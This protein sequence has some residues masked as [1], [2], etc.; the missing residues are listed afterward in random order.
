MLLVSDKRHLYAKHKHTV[1]PANTHIHTYVTLLIKSTCHKYGGFCSST[2]TLIVL[3]FLSHLMVTG[4]LSFLHIYHISQHIFIMYT[5]FALVCRICSWT[6]VYETKKCTDMIFIHKCFKTKVDII[7]LRAKINGS[8]SWNPVANAFSESLSASAF[9]YR[10]RTCVQNLKHPGWAMGWVWGLCGWVFYFFLNVDD[11]SDGGP[12]DPYRG[13]FNFSQLHHQVCMNHSFCR[14]WGCVLQI[15]QQICMPCWR[16]TLV[17]NT[18]LT[19]VPSLYSLL[20]IS[21][22]IYIFL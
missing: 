9:R 21:F 10:L 7:A 4:I 6:F 2:C 12:I 16:K 5:I 19:F 11:F 18:L 13:H 22:P 3:S 20:S 14:T 17:G 1:I 8:Y 15:E